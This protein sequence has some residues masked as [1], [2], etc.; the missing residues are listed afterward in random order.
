MV[1]GGVE[2]GPKM[3]GGGLETLLEDEETTAADVIHFK[4]TNY[5]SDD[6]ADGGGNV[7]DFDGVAKGFL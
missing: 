6:K 4:A 3:F 7:V 5:V 2:A 1:Y